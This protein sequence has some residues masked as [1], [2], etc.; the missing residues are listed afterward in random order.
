MVRSAIVAGVLTLAVAV[1][2]VAVAQRARARDPGYRVNGATQ[3]E[4]FRSWLAANRDSVRTL[5]APPRAFH[6]AEMFTAGPLGGPVWSGRLL[7]L[8]AT[9]PGIAPPRGDYVVLYSAHSSLCGHCRLGAT[10]VLGNPVK[11]PSSWQSIFSTPD[12]ILQVYVVR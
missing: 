4:Q 9:T 5:W 10:Q 2:P 6:L 8:S 1:V 12:G 3:L 11:V 7:S